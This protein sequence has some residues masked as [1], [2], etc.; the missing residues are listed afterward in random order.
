MRMQIFILF[1]G[2]KFRLKLFSAYSLLSFF[3]FL[4]LPLSHL[5]TVFLFKK[6]KERNRRKMFVQSLL[7]IEF[8]KDTINRSNSWSML[9][10]SLLFSSSF[11]FSRSLSL[12]LSSENSGRILRMFWEKRGWQL[13]DKALEKVEIMEVGGVIDTILWKFYQRTFEDSM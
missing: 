10:F 12:S 1:Q 4:S 5:P 13:H 8:G 3:F 9:L 11:F 7:G 6:E 2:F